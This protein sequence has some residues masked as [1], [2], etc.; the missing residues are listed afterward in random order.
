MRS[1]GVRPLVFEAFIECVCLLLWSILHSKHAL[2]QEVALSDTADSFT[3]RDEPPKMA[4]TR[5][6]MRSVCACACVCA[7]VRVS[8]RA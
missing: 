7:C 2:L 4:G 5:M 6:R 3:G 1:P 8:L